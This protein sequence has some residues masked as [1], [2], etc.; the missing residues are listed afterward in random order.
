M[1]TLRNTFHGTEV[2]TR[3]SEEDREAIA[4]RVYAGTATEAEKALL[5]RIR[6]ALCPWAGCT[7]G[8]AWGE[9]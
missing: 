1:E 8:N 3:T 6:R 4:Y 2:Q 5:R 7:C 9:R